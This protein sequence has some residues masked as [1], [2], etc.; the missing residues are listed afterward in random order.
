ME[1]SLVSKQI[2]VRILRDGKNQLVKV[3]PKDLNS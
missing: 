3:T 1:N 2:Q